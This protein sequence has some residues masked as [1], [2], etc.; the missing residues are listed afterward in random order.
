MAVI[1]PPQ[2]SAGAACVFEAEELLSPEAFVSQLDELA[3]RLAEAYAK[4]DLPVMATLKQELQKFESQKKMH[5]RGSCV[6]S[7]LKLDLH[8]LIVYHN[9]I[10][11]LDGHIGLA[12]GLTCATGLDDNFQCAASTLAIGRGRFLKPVRVYA[13]E[14][15]LGVEFTLGG[16]GAGS[17]EATLVYES[18]AFLSG[19]KMCEMGL[20]S[21]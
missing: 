16:D 2:P 21:F 7:N 10:V 4:E 18:G 14:L 15:V 12:I 17:C 3:T 8:S 6:T 5:L 20:S 9:A 1:A 19:T 11:R 13:P